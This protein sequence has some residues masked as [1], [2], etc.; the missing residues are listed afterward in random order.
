MAADDPSDDS[1]EQPVGEEAEDLASKLNLETAVI[2][3]ADLV[4]HFAR[5]VVIR[6]GGNVDLIEAAACLARDDTK[7]LQAWLDS[8]DV[9][10]ASDDDARDWTQREPDFWCVVTAPWVLVQERPDGVVSETKPPT[11]H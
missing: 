7:V 6:V 10:R 1:V 3:W 9:S 8:G 5:G 2:A 4:K 11:M